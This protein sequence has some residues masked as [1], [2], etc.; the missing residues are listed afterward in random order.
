MYKTHDLCM[1]YVLSKV[2]VAREQTII[3][4]VIRW[5]EESLIY[6]AVC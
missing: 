3:E 2:S 4:Q 1:Y 6:L 5:P